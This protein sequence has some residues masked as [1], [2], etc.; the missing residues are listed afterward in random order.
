MLKSEYAGNKQI[1]FFDFINKHKTAERPEGSDYFRKR[2]ITFNI[3]SV[4]HIIVGQEL[5]RTRQHELVHIAFFQ[6]PIFIIYIFKNLPNQIFLKYFL[7]V[8]SE[9]LHVLAKSAGQLFGYSERVFYSLG[10]E[11]CTCSGPM[12][13]FLSRERVQEIFM[14]HTVPIRGKKR[15]HTGS[16]FFYYF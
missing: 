11:G 10:G 8:T 3:A 13:N 12:K 15:K 6:Q 9:R 16:L 7:S 4:S 1:Q 5:L 2:N 14:G